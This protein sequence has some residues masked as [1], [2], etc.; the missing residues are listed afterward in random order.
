MTFATGVVK[1]RRVAVPRPDSL[2]QE[3][4]DEILENVGIPKAL[5]WLGT[6]YIVA[7]QTL[8]GPTAKGFEIYGGTGLTVNL[9]VHGG[10]I[11]RGSRR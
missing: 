2:P 10:G 8:E 6:D 7:V 3:L 9:R 1:P 4:M 5:L 11:D